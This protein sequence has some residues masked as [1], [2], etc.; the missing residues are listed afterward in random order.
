MIRWEEE[1]I[2]ESAQKTKDLS[3]LSEEFRNVFNQRIETNRSLQS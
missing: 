1:A 3:K 2:A